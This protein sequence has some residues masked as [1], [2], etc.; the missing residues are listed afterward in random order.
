MG[1]VTEPLGSANLQRLREQARLTQHEAA[2][3]LSRRGAPWHRSKIAAIESGERPNVSIA[4]VLLLAHTFNVELAELFDGDGDVELSQLATLPR[5]LIRDIIRGMASL[6]GSKDWDPHTRHDELLGL[7]RIRTAGEGTRFGARE[8][9]QMLAR[10]L[11]VPVR[12]VTE[13]ARELW[14]KT[15]TDERDERVNQLGDLPLSERPAHRGHITRE[16]SHQIE[17]ELRARGLLPDQPEPTNENE[18]KEE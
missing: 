6:E 2:R 8:A 3:L 11:D 14:D 7:A 5:P 1:V 9:D 17:D 12:A 10:R 16:L 4:D 13:I 18:E 15:L